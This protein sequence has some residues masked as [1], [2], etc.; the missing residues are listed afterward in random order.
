MK[1]IKCERCDYTEEVENFVKSLVC[2]NCDKKR[3]LEEQLKQR[4]FKSV[5]DLSQHNHIPV[6]DN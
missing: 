4:S 6:E 5:S 1:T 3:Q 2:E